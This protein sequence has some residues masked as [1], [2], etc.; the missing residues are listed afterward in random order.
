[1]KKIDFFIVYVTPRGTQGFTKKMSLHS[2][3][4]DIG[5]I[6]KCLVSLYKRYIEDVFLSVACDICWKG[7]ITECKFILN[8]QVLSCKV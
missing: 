7:W 3:R 8:L 2:V 5:N 1:M 6:Y 4:P